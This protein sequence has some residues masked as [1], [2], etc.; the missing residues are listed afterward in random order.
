MGRL[1]LLPALLLL[2]L[3]VNAQKTT[4]KQNVIY[5]IKQMDKAIANK[6]SVTLKNILT[7]DFIGSVPNG[8]S[9]NKKSYI[10]Y[11]CSPQSKVRELKEEPTAD[12]SVRIYTNIAIVNRTVTALVKTVGKD[13]PVEIQLRRLEVCLKIKG[14]WFV[15]SG[16]GTE[17]LKK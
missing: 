14:K 10:T 1:I 17:V 8:Q 5:L 9:F 13:K 12:W 16:Q 2:A 6:D 3:P 4:E 7:E 15:A 11:Y